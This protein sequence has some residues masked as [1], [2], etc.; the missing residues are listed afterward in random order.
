[1]THAFNSLPLLE[2]SDE[3]TGELTEKD[4]VLFANLL[5]VL[6]E[7]GAERKF[8]VCL[9]HRHFDIEDDEVMTEFIDLDNK[10]RPPAYRLQAKPI[11]GSI[12][13]NTAVLTLDHLGQTNEGW[14]EQ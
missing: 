1:M 13:F 12:Q 11:E 14:H 5:A 6:K 3:L 2:E 7:H 8:G 10:A 9:L 4:K